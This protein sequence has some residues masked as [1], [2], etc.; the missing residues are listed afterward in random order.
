MRGDLADVEHSMAEPAAPSER[1]RM[2]KPVMEQQVSDSLGLGTSTDGVHQM[3]CAAETFA[4]RWQGLVV[5]AWE[6]VVHQ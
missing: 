6:Y 5:E 4:R 3:R 2:K 1:T